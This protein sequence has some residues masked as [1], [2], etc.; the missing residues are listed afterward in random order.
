MNYLVSLAVLE[1]T[2]KKL[3]GENCKLINTSMHQRCILSKGDT[4]NSVDHPSKKNSVDQS[5]IKARLTHYLI[6]SISYIM[7]SIYMGVQFQLDSKETHIKPEF[8]V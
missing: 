7:F 2:I 5:G 8:I 3:N 4:K 1:T 6:E